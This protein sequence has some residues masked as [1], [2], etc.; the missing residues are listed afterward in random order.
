MATPD[1]EPLDVDL[2][3]PLS[4]LLADPFSELTRNLFDSHTSTPRP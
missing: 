4:E 2:G 3:K 1:A